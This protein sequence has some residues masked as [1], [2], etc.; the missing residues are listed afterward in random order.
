MKKSTTWVLLLL[1]AACSPIKIPNSN[2]YK[3][4]AY[5]D[6]QLTAHP[7]K[8][9]ILVATPEAVAGYQ[10]EDMLYV[11]KPFELSSFA[12]NAWM[13]PPAAMLLPLI[14]QSLQRSGYFYAVTS[15]THS[16]STDYRVDTQLIKLQQNFLTKPSHV[17]LVVKVVLSNVNDNRV[18]ASRLI[19]QQVK[20][21]TDTPYGGVTAANIAAKNFTA[22]ATA[23]V[24]SQVKLDSSH[25]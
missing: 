9:S 21:P 6:K 24:V 20:C 25:N 22:E 12:N 16:E 15:S 4:E 1:L 7:S 5:S 14:A 23:F 18:V 13:D 19:S 2:E 8:L 3:L 17:D 10:N 11:K